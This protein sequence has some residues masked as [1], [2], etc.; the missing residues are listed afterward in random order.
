MRKPAR[1]KG[2]MLNVERFALTNVRASALLFK[3]RN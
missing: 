3:S 1:S 2:E